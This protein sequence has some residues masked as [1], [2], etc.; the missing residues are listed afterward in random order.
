MDKN[1]FLTEDRFVDFRDESISRLANTLFAVCHSDAEKAEAAFLYVRDEIPH[2]FDIRAKIITHTASEVLRHKTGICH[3]KANLLAAL[4][5][6]VGL[7]TGF[8]F[9]H[10]TFAD[11]D[12]QDYCLHCYNAVFLNEKW[13]QLDA[14]GNKPGVNAQFSLDEPILAFPC[15]KEYDEYIFN[16][17]YAKPDL[18]TMHLLCEAMNIDEV[19]R[20]LP[21]FPANKPDLIID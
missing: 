15:R 19:A 11:D 13:I 9:Q 21:E 2:S 6:S 12:S 7:P 1:A 18:P 4:L 14:R 8:R 17:I 3:A 5:R 16:G 10:I 20:G